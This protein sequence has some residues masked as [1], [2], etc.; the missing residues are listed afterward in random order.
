[1]KWGCFQ[2]KQ[3]AEQ[4]IICA[5]FAVVQMLLQD[6]QQ[7][8]SV[9]LRKAG[10]RAWYDHIA[11]RAGWLFA[12]GIMPENRQSFLA[13]HRVGKRPVL[14]YLIERAGEAQIR[15]SAASIPL[16]ALMWFTLIVVGLINPLL[17]ALALVVKLVK[18]WQTRQR[19]LKLLGVF[20]DY[21]KEHA[22]CN[23]AE[24]TTLDTEK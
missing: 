11:S 24:Y 18:T 10:V 8:G 9:V 12:S 21:I 3:T 22:A 23:P 6:D 14:V 15:I 5:D 19:S 16:P 2:K 1:M 7:W 4:V 17:L 20:C 13:Y